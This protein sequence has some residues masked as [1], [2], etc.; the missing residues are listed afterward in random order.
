MNIKLH[1]PLRV[2]FQNCWHNWSTRSPL[3]HQN[4]WQSTGKKF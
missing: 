1:K 3:S 4:K 2:R